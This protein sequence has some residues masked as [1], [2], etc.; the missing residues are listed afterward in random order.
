[1][2]SCRSNCRQRGFALL[3]LVF[4]VAI[5]A[6]LL[7]MAVL[8]SGALI[9]KESGRGAIYEIQ[10]LAQLARME[11]VARNREC[12][13]LLSP[14]LRQMAVTDTLGTSDVSDDEVLH[15]TAFS[16]AVRFERPDSG[17][18]VTWTSI[19]GSPEWFRVRFA[20]D[21]TIEAG[22]GDVCIHGG[23]RYGR[24]SLHASGGSRVTT[25]GQGGWQA[26]KF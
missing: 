10:T 17:S 23:D 6:A 3:E 24:V 11:A 1:M 19:G 16:E 21:G 14:S 20:S 15:G 4:V 7:A 18:A 9:G 8:V 5:A 22:E 12:Q 13:L 2:C 25:W 26:T